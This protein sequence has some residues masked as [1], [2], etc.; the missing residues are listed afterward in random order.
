VSTDTPD[1]GREAALKVAAHY[2]RWP[3]PGGDHGGRE[4][5][6]FVRRLTE[7]CVEPSGA[8]ER[9][10]VLDAGCGTGHTTLALARR[11]PG[12]DFLGLDVS[13]ASI[14]V[15]RSLVEQQ[16][17]DNVTFEVADIAAA[18]PSAAVPSE[19]SFRAVLALGVLHH[20]PDR[21]AALDNLVGSLEP[22]GHLALWLY[23]LHGRRAHALHQKFIRLL[24]GPDASDSDLSRVGL[25]FV[26]GLGEQYLPASGVYTPVEDRGSPAGWL[27]RHPEWLADQMF[28]AYERPVDLD[29]ILDLL[30]SRALELEEW[31]GVPE[32]SDRWT[33]ESVLRERL[34]ALPRLERLRALECL[35][36]PAYYFVTARP[37]GN[38]T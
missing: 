23:G 21:E 15:A 26:E 11:L 8:G 17:V 5:F 14:E 3:F 27:S 38:A 28:P 12:T 4:G 16:E 32:E 33:G 10:R 24:A 36:K 29:G 37:G 35:L 30:E 7:W 25:A 22:E 31:L 20:V 9:P 1:H 19:G 13:T 18:D 2:E 6:L 34:A